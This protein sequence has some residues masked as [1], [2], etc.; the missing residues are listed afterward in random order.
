MREKRF[1]RR[2]ARVFATIF[3]LIVVAMVGTIVAFPVAAA[4]ACPTCYGL[5][6]LSSNV[7]VERTLAPE[8]R[9]HVIDAVAEARKRVRDFYG[10]FESD[11][12]VLVCSS[13]TCYRHIGGGHTRG[14]SFF[15]LALILSP[16]G[17]DQVIAAHELSHIEL[18]HRVGFVRFLSGTI[19]AWFDEGL[20]VVVSDD[21][22]YLAP[23]GVA[24]RCLFRSDELLPNGMF[25][26]SKRADEDSHIYA[27]A[28]CRVSEWMARNGGSGAIRRLVS[29]VSDGV[30]FSPAYVSSP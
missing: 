4:I 1:R 16:R 29:Q 25:D 8:A 13:E 3:A 27:A 2:A 17:V 23:V 21:P 12:R 28:A 9:A 10:Q 30:P 22:R 5:E 11:P 26:W 18:H 7:F 14:K 20:A 6:P 15:D 24:D 19:P